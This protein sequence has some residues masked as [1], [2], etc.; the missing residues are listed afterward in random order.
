M[1]RARSGIPQD[2]SWFKSCLL[3]RPCRSVRPVSERTLPILLQSPGYGPSRKTLP[4]VSFIRRPPTPNAAHLPA[5]PQRLPENLF[6]DI[7]EVLERVKNTRQLKMKPS[8]RP[9][10]EVRPGDRRGT[11]SPLVEEQNV[12]AFTRTRMN[13]LFPG[14]VWRLARHASLLPRACAIE[15]NTNL[16]YPCV[17][18][19]QN[20]DPSLIRCSVCQ[21]W[22]HGRCV[23]LGHS[24]LRRMA[25]NQDEWR[26]LNHRTTTQPTPTPLTPIG[27]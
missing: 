11:A 25:G 14:G 22:H 20:V 16:R 10:Q 13:P 12:P 1:K 5:S 24:Q 7:S 3:S 26:C 4:E 21:R 9:L 18:C 19:E 6:A 8:S 27:V 17:A 2:R 23:G 15:T